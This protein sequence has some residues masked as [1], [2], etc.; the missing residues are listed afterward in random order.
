MCEY[1]M[2]YRHS[3]SGY[4]YVLNVR[5]VDVVFKNQRMAAARLIS[6]MAAINY[7]FKFQQINAH[8]IYVKNVFVINTYI[9]SS[10]RGL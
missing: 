4:I 2:S 7:C 3:S 10:I 1:L 6:K 8:Y 5:E 9:M